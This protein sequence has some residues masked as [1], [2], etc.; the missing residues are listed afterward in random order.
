MSH[1]YTRYTL[2][3]ASIIA[4]IARP[5][6]AAANAAFATLCVAIFVLFTAGGATAGIP[7]VMTQIGN[8]AFDVVDVNLFS[9]NF[10]PT[11]SFEVSL[12][13]LPNHG[14]YFDESTASALSNL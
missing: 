1:T 4:S 8:P 14:L 11:M 12:T 3:L 9:P 6:I 5:R 13:I 7:I 2:A 10:V